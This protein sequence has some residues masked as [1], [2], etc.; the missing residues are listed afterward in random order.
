ME[1]KT[2][3]SSKHT[4][5]DV[6]EMRN[7]GTLRYCPRSL[8]I[9]SVTIL[10]STSENKLPCKLGHAHPRRHDRSPVGVHPGE[11]AQTCQGRWTGVFSAPGP[12]A[13]KR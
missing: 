1:E 12:M 3:R 10:L 8:Y 13:R 11:T 5:T 4:V 6:K 2:Q 9:G 7:K